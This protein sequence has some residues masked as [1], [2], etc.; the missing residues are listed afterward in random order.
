MQEQRRSRR[1][2]LLMANDS[3]EPHFLKVA[4]WKKHHLEEDGRRPCYNEHCPIL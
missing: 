2:R 3:P 1:I 4:A